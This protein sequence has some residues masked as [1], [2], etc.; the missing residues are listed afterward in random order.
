MSDLL[1]GDMGPVAYDLAIEGGKLKVSLGSQ[2]LNGV[3]VEL[4]V[5]LDASLLLDKLKALIPG[6]IDDVVIDAIKAAI[7]AK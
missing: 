5:S 2:K 3:D 4:S 6:S 7:A 1:K